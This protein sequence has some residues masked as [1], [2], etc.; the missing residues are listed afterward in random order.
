VVEPGVA[1]EQLVELEQ[2]VVG[3]QLAAVHLLQLGRQVPD[4][5]LHARREQQV[6]DA[7]LCRLGDGHV[8][9]R[10]PKA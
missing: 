3:E 6:D 9:R 4:V 8:A 5:E 1:G 2:V 7:G 10:A